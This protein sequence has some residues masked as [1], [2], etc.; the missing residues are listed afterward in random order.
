M[1]ANGDDTMA[2]AKRLMSRVR[3]A[4]LQTAFAAWKVSLEHTGR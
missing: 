2:K 4:K 1:D 3:A